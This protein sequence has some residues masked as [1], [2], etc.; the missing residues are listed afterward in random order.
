MIRNEAVAGMFYEKNETDLIKQLE[1]CFLSEKLILQN[2][3]K[4]KV[5]GIISP[6]A[7]YVYSGQCAAYGFNELL[8]S[9]I[10]DIYFLIG[11]NHYSN[12]SA[13]SCI[14]WK[15]PLGILEC[16]KKFVKE[17]SKDTN[18]PI[19]EEVH[20]NEHSIEV[21][22]PFLQFV[23]KDFIDKFKIVCLSV[24]NDINVT[25]V[26][27]KIKE[28][29]KNSKK[30]VTFIVSSDFTH[31][32]VRFG[33]SPFDID[34][35]QNLNQLDHNAIDLILKK[36]VIGFNNYIDD[37][38]ATICGYIPIL[39]FL[40]ILDKKVKGKLLS[41]YDSSKI[42]NNDSNSVSYASIVFR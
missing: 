12:K 29:L 24:S 32:G 11:P 19:D 37:T 35:K 14:D 26:S 17:V 38:G 2:K 31:Y 13:F 34:I 28:Y 7:G 22:L 5:L 41:Y 40:S 10:S 36:D 4:E 6:H 9:E 30:S 33:Y 42:S 39:I 3:R 25:D 15:T 27:K 18:I 1:L 16:D 8:K 21:Q 23:N 20:K